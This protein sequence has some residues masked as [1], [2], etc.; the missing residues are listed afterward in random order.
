MIHGVS[1]SL[2]SPFSAIPRTGQT[3][4]WIGCPLPLDVTNECCPGHQPYMVA[5][6]CLS[7]LPSFAAWLELQVLSVLEF[8]NHL[9]DNRS[10]WLV[11]CGHLGESPVAHVAINVPI[12]N[13]VKF[14][15]LHSRPCPPPFFF[16]LPLH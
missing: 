12:K 10:S 3:A 4:N 15:S 2:Y 9:V 7:E 6:Q 8:V 1:I 5:H 13:E 14:L 11:S 16:G